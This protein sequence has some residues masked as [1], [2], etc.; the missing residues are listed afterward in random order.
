[1]DPKDPIQAKHI[2]LAIASDYITKIGMTGAYIKCPLAAPGEC[3]YTDMS[4]VLPKSE[5]I[6]LDET[7][8]GYNGKVEYV[9]KFIPGVGPWRIHAASTDCIVKHIAALNT[10]YSATFGPLMSQR[11]YKKAALHIRCAVVFQMNFLQNTLTKRSGTDAVEVS[12]LEQCRGEGSVLLNEDEFNAY[13]LEFPEGPLLKAKRGSTPPFPRMCNDWINTPPQSDAKQDM[14]VHMS[15]DSAEESGSDDDS[16]AYTSTDPYA[17]S[18][19]DHGSRPDEE[20]ESDQ[21]ITSPW[22]HDEEAEAST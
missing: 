15:S 12:M 8:R 4:F 7:D 10:E 16:E 1:M 9:G 11:K 6:E 14:V 19:T 2:W 3:T 17:E 22:D 18:D 20:Y 13:L 21:D 5:I